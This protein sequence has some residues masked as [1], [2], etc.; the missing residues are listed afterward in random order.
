[1]KNIMERLND[2]V[3]V[4]GPLLAGL[5]PDKDK[6]KILSDTIDYNGADCDFL[7]NYCFE[8]IEAFGRFWTKQ[9]QM[10]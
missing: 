6:L 7:R 8:Y 2:A 1:M 5:D 10:G 9:K 4:K 3:L